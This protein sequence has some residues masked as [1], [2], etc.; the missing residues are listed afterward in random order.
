MTTDKIYMLRLETGF[1]DEFYFFHSKVKAK[2]RL[3]EYYKAHYSDEPENM[4]KAAKDQ[5]DGYDYIE[6]VGSVYGYVFED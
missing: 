1:G 6:D 3:W 4:R 2:Q 5:F